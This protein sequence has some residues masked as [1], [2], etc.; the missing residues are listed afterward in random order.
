MEKYIAS[1]VANQMLASDYLY[2]SFVCLRGDFLES[3]VFF[4]KPAQNVKTRPSRK[5][6]LPPSFVLKFSKNICE[7]K[8]NFTGFLV[9]CHE[10][11]HC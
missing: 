8:E 6:A 11:K 10:A 2:D 4:A 5:N 7:E 3:R 1:R 9:I